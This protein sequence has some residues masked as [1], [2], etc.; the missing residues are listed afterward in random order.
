MQSDRPTT[1]II[2]NIPGKYSE[3]QEL[4]SVK[5]CR[6]GRG[7]LQR[8]S[9]LKVVSWNIDFASPEPAERAAVAIQHLQRAFGDWP[10]Q[11][12]IV[13]QEVCNSSLQQVL[14]TRWVQQNFVL[15]G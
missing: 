15:T 4:S 13:L 9:L 7:S 2:A 1:H 6:D 11:L 3:W 8:N 14:Q 5:S 10:G 12:A